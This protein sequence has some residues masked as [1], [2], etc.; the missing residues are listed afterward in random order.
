MQ[1][2]ASDN[3]SKVLAN[4]YLLLDSDFLGSLFLDVEFLK[5]FVALSSRSIFLL[6]PFIIFEFMRDV[7]D[8]KYIDTKTRFL[9][10]SLFTP[11]INRQESL[12]KVQEN[13]ILLS[14]IYAHKQKAKSVSTID[15][16]LA[17]R[18]MILQKNTLLVTGNRKDYPS[19]V[20]KLLSVINI[21]DRNSESIKSFSV[22][23]F[24]QVAFDKSN[25][26]LLKVK[27]G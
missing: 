1:L 9:N 15:L 17:S 13:A 25:H 21:E 5:Q 22:L 7:Y 27:A 23:A 2:I 12:V 6:E 19:C 18:L 16:F 24:D 14:K 4:H 11:I 3:L 8:P 20:F 10:D 26:E